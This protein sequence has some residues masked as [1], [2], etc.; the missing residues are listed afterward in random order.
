MWVL[1]EF[2]KSGN[3]NFVCVF[4]SSPR[5]A[6]TTSHPA[7]AY[8]TAVHRNGTNQEVKTKKNENPK[9]ANNS[10]KEKV[11]TTTMT[12]PFGIDVHPFSSSNK[13]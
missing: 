4:V 8:F 2:S 12:K 6:A 10:D 13:Q 9:K 11:Q 5:Q 3:C 1:S 7:L